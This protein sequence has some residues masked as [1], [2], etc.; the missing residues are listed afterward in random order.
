ML[1][2][3]GKLGINNCLKGEILFIFWTVN[4]KWRAKVVSLGYET[5]SFEV[6][7][8]EEGRGRRAKD[9]TTEDPLKIYAYLYSWI[10]RKN[11]FED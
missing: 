7:F 9:L 6:P 4:L 3:F 1:T 10:F 11:V 2:R 8:S 5:S